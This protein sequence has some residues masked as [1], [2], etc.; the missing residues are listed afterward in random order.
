MP[1]SRTPG[2]LL[3]SAVRWSR[4]F[5]RFLSQNRSP[6]QA[7]IP[8]LGAVPFWLLLRCAS[9]QCP[10]SLGGNVFTPKRP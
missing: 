7:P 9:V 10:M 1:G 4:H 6:F 3:L 8:D 2:L 5:F